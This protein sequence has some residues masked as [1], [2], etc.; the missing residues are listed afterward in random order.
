MTPTLEQTI[1]REDLALFVNACFVS[2]GQKEFYSTAAEQ[3]ISLEFLH[4]YICTHYRRLYTRCLAVGVN[5]Y[6][7]TEIVRHL[8]SS[9]KLCP[10]DF[11]LEEGRLIRAS[12][13]KLPPQRVWKLFERLRKDGL[14]NRR[15]RATVREYVMGH[16]ELP[17]QAIKYRHKLRSSLMHA[18]IHLDDE[19]SSFLFES[20]FKKSVKFETP[21]LET[22]RAA[23][24]SMEK[25]YELPYSIAEGLAAKHG[26][27]RAKFLQRI[28]PRMTEREK[29]RL[30]ASSGG[31]IALD[32]SKLELTEL[33][34]YLLSLTFDQR[35]QNRAQLED[36]LEIA[37][38]KAARS[39]E[40]LEGKVAAV[41]DNSFS[42]SG[43]SEKK[44]RP[45]ALAYS[46]HR[47]LKS[48]A[49][50]YRAFW[51]A[52]MPDELLLHA[53]GQSNLTERFLDA[54]E[55]GAET[56]IIVSDAAENDPS[57]AFHS[58]YSA[59]RKLGGKAA[60]LH[61]NPF[62]DAENLEVAPLSPDLPALGLRSSED[63]S[64][65]L[66]FAPFFSGEA[67]LQDLESYLGARAGKLLETVARDVVDE[68]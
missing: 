37:T 17:F 61:L 38:R 19:L 63:L 56:V 55:T 42:S 9:G 15:T 58:I 10:D 6:A 16:P 30:Q 62:F 13:R 23:H 60:V 41:M 7:R 46:I 24:Y 14:N 57:S 11:R 45:L 59:Y 54:L 39:L 29:L 53:K 67:T 2:T 47:L 8:L 50:D 32:P 33:C 66:G 64:A 34:V 43:S 52:P 26:I 22:F 51:T 27:P 65:L 18:H 5:H 36:Y 31:K 4:N 12:L 3:R 48:V 28:Q 20:G 35:V 44:N 49:A 68:L 1:P 40:P 21:L 25:V